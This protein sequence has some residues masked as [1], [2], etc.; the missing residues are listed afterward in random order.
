MG[1]RRPCTRT[2]CNA[3]LGAAFAGRS[4]RSWTVTLQMRQT[5]VMVSWSSG[6]DWLETT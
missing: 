2:G 1:I 4:S 6:M 3:G 5:V